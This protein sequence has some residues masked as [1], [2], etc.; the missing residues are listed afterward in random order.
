MA[1]E[2]YIDDLI[3]DDYIEHIFPFDTDRLV[4]N[5]DDEEFLRSF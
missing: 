2:Q 4:D 5:D 1:E 3:E